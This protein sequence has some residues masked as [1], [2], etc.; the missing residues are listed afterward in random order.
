MTSTSKTQVAFGSDA[1]HIAALIDQRRA[2][3]AQLAGVDVELAMAVGDRDAARR[4]LQEM[5]AQ[6]EARYAARTAVASKGAH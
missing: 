6:T 3:A 1:H 2:L 5:K 4:A